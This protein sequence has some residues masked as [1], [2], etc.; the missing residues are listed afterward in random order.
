MPS[1]GE[2]RWR[3][4]KNVPA[5]SFAGCIYVLPS[6]LVV[7]RNL[8]IVNNHDNIYISSIKI[9]KC[10]TDNGAIFKKCSVPSISCCDTYGQ[11]S[12]EVSI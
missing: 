12:R 10:F 9:S 6:G 4:E 11:T 3:T 5:P 2:N 8:L 1:I 7:Q